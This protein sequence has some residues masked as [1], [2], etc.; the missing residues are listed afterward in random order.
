MFK[1]KSTVINNINNSPTPRATS[2]RGNKRNS[3]TS[4]R[5]YEILDYVAA[6]M[7]GKYTIDVSINFWLQKSFIYIY[8]FFFH[9][10]TSS[11]TI[12]CF[13]EKTV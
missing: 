11:I 6:R 5:F 9:K 12:W 3:I 4:P 2:P 10:T 1:R 13:Y 7:N 8:I